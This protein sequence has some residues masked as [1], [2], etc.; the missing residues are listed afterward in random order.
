MFKKY[1]FFFTT[2][3]DTSFCVKYSYLNLPLHDFRNI[4]EYKAYKLNQEE[5]DYLYHVH[6]L[7]S[8]SLVLSNFEHLIRCMMLQSSVEH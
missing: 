8:W 4:K 7:S 2:I 5:S 1:R 3:R 6:Q